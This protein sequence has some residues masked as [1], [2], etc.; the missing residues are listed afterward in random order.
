MDYVLVQNGEVKGYPRPLPEVWENISNFHVLDLETHK[1][2][3]WY[4]LRFVSAEKGENDVVTGQEY[5]I[6]E[7][8]VVQYE[9]IRP[10]TTEEL[11]E[12]INQKWQ[13]IR[14]ERNQLLLQSDWTQLSDSPLSDVKKEEWKIY[15]QSLRDITNFETPDQVVWP[16]KPE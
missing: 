1:Q 10:K 4:P 14:Y 12:E 11:Q 13:S 9:R 3:G 7:D 16:T 8:E 2:W 15:R 5:V 6:G